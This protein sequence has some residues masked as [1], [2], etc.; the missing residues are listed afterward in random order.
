LKRTAS[1]LLH[2][3]DSRGLLLTEKRKMK[4][5]NPVP[6]APRHQEKKK[7]TASGSA[8]SRTA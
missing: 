6:F 2:A 5:P 1:H 3:I 7:D 8:F 4:A